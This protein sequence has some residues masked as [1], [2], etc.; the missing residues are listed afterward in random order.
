[1]GISV[2]RAPIIIL[3]LGIGIIARL[4]LAPQELPIG[5]LTD[6]VAGSYFCYLIACR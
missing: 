6:A 1:M 5:V 2:N 4:L 3:L